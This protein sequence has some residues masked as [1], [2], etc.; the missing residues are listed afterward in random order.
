MST[1]GERDSLPK[2][3]YSASFE[4]WWKHY[5]R[6]ESK[7]DAWKAWEATRKARTMPALQD[8]SA[9][10]DAYARKVKGDDPKF[11]KLPAG[12]IRDRKWE[13]E[14]APADGGGWGNLRALGGAA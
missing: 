10:A 3:P 7:G 6:K 13:D 5:P 11:V 8:L 2:S 12:W 4:E 14:T 1:V 9:A